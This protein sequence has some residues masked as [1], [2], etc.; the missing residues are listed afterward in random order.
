[1]GGS[2]A[3]ISACTLPLE[4][5]A[6]SWPS[7]SGCGA[8]GSSQVRSGQTI[9]QGGVRALYRSRCPSAEAPIPLYPS[10]CAPMPASPLPA[11]DQ[12]CDSAPFQPPLSFPLQIKPFLDPNAFKPLKL[13]HKK[14]LNHNTVGDLHGGR[15]VYQYRV[16]SLHGEAIDVFSMRAAV[17]VRCMWCFTSCG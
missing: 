6:A 16:V 12:A 7:R 9:M 13:K 10:L 3:L 8:L 14:L 5:C 17:H 15:S 2:R 4:P 11:L 1:M